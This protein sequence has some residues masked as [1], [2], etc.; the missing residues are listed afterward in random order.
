[1]CQDWIRPHSLIHP[2]L[3]IV[4]YVPADVLDAKVVTVNKASIVCILIVYVYL[5]EGE[6]QQINK[7]GKTHAKKQ[8]GVYS[9]TGW[10][11]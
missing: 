11:C 9:V 4:C 10:M 8:G 3:L 7:P 2:E 5:C 6:K 1:M